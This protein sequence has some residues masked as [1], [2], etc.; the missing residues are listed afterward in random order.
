[1][2]PTRS[3]VAAAMAIVTL[4]ACSPITTAGPYA[5]SD[6]VR[7]ELGQHV[8]GDNLMVL[9]AAEGAQGTVV[10]TLTNRGPDDTVVSMAIDGEPVTDVDVS[11]GQTVRLGPGFDI[12]VPL[13]A[14]GAP[15]GATVPVTVSSPAVGATALSLPVLD[16]TLA[17]YADLV[18]SP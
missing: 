14:V 6:G 8:V 18:P 12:E 4:T 3:L 13:E 9:A 7:F 10:G 1:M 17:E 15:P 2:A 11:A 16:G 5:A